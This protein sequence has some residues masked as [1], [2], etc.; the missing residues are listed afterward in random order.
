MRYTK[1]AIS[2]AG[3]LAKMKARGLV[4][5]DDAIA[6]DR[7][8]HLGYYR[9]SAYSLPF[10]E[11]PDRTVFKTATSF[12]QILRLYSFD[13]ELRLL[14]IDAIER[15]EVAARARMVHETCC[16]LGAH[17]FMDPANYRSGFDH[18]R[19]TKKVEDAVNIR[20]DW[21]TGHK[22]YPTNHSE[23]FIGHYY[24]KYGD[25][26]LPPFWMT[27][28]V[29]TLGTLSFIFK[30]L[31]SNP[32]RSQI[33][34]GFSVPENIFVGWLHAIA[35]LRNVCAHHGRL[36]NRSFS[37]KPPITRRHRPLVSSPDR[38]YAHA[39]VL[40]DMLRHADAETQWQVGLKKLLA[41]Y[42][43]IDTTAMGFPTNWEQ[44][45]LWKD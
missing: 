44:E 19:F 28:E 36:W 2:L 43:E 27:A 45:P 32:L 21:R 5:P 4:V 16:S 9:L 35:H 11:P 30:Q 37:I 31:R 29:L 40:M 20:I 13:R 12:D 23:V 10:L 33:A 22:I 18:A 1:P 7:L 38:F 24:R 6:L 3:Q 25:P 14:V 15:I 34:S 8:A 26:D 42:P 41:V 39:V 17:W